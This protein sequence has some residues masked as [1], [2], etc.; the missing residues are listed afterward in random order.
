MQRRKEVA[1]FNVQ[2]SG[3]WCKYLCVLCG[4]PAITF[5]VYE[6]QETANKYTKKIISKISVIYVP[7]WFLFAI[8]N[9]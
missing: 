1:Q 2:S 3:R 8:D 5:F 9:S 6:F 4:K 7:N